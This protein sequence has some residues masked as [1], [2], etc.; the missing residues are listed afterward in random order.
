[1]IIS[2][3][4][5]SVYLSLYLKRIL[6]NTITIHIQN[7]K[8]DFSKFDFIIAPNHDNI[9]GENV[10]NSVGAIHQF[11]KNNI[12][13]NKNNFFIPKKNLVSFIIG[14]KNRHY[15]FIKKNIL[16]LVEKITKLKV[17]YPKFNFLIISS[18]RTGNDLNNILEKKLNKIAYV[19]DRKE[20]NPYIFALK[21][22]KI[23]VVTSDSTSMISECAFT[24]KPIYVYNL[25]FRRKSKRMEYFHNEFKKLQITQNFSNIDKLK[26]WK[27]KSLDEAKRIS[28]ILKERIIKG[29]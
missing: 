20:K 6:K 13:E 8:V 1:M 5:K 12:I 11:T 26:E 16:E 14:G 10:I 28:G 2:C 17:K 3:G 4:R 23:F 27:Y 9:K 25:P 29:F 22:S 7:P 19:W 15:N 24:G 18:R 21:Y